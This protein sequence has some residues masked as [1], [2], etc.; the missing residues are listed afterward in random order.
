MSMKITALILVATTAISTNSMEVQS[1][2]EGDENQLPRH[3]SDD[4]THS[5]MKR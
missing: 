4:D 1:I 2:D 3:E 5:L